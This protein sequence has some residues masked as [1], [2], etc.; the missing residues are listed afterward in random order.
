MNR[1]FVLFALLATGIILG[2]GITFAEQSN[3]KP[4]ARSS[5]EKSSKSQGGPWLTLPATQS[6]KSQGGPL[7]TLPPTQSSK[8]QG[9]PLLTDLPTQ[10]SKSHP[11]NRYSGIGRGGPL[12]IDQ[13]AQQFHGTFRNLVKIGL[14]AT[15][16]RDSK[17]GDYELWPL[18]DEQK[19][20]A[21]LGVAEYRRKRSEMDKDLAELRA[22]LRGEKD[23]TRKGLLTS[24]YEREAKAFDKVP[25]PRPLN[26]NLESPTYYKVTKLGIDFVGLEMD[27]AQL[28]IRLSSIRTIRRGS[29]E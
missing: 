8:S 1:R 26:H 18:T 19:S 7:L 29:P 10:S 24:Q 28:F 2:H 13:P 23:Q 5:T 22:Q 3:A 17:S 12:G 4:S 11:R 25:V 20:E 9:G 16:S 6:P 15:L 14:W 27:G 21:Q